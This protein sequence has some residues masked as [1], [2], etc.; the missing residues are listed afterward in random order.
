MTMDEV[1]ERF[2]LT[3]YKTWMASRAQEGLS[4]AGGVN[5][6]V[7]SRPATVR[8]AEG[9]IPV[10]PTETKHSIE[11]RDKSETTPQ[12][13]VTSPTISPSTPVERRSIE[14]RRS[15][16]G[17]EKPKDDRAT[18]PTLEEVTTNATHDPK[19]PDHHEDETDDD[20]DHIHTALGPDILDHPGDSCAICIDTL[21]DDDDIRGLTCGHAFH[22]SCLDPWL[23]SRRAS[24]PLCKADYYVP[25]PRAE[26]EAEAEQR[27]SRRRDRESPRV[28]LPQPPRG[29]WGV[30]RSHPRMYLPGRFMTGPAYV[31]GTAYDSYGRP[32]GQSRRVR[33]AQGER[34]GEAEQVQRQAQGQGWGA[35]MMGRL[36]PW[37][38]EGRHG[39]GSTP[40]ATDAATVTP[41]QL[42]GQ[43]YR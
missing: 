13:T 41:A 19:N 20:D 33:L 34:Q 39:S 26:G 18:L 36:A 31:G 27:S 35:T 15:A 17:T 23:T 4:T 12:I 25:K 8:D 28:N 10:S 6:P 9:V 42:E 16:D 32:A 14:V 24:C 11:S 43:T 30:A 1:N 22:A 38:R 29:V 21:E 7:G 5:P 3:K 40:A 2:P 37:R